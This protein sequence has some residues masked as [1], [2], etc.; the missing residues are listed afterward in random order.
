MLL[1]VGAPPQVAQAQLRHSD[2]RITLE[3]YA[4]AIGDSQRNAV[5]K[6][7]ELLCPD[8]PEVESAGKWIQ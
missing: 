2:S 8:V 5:E 1:D 3:V 6:V 7:A 4:H